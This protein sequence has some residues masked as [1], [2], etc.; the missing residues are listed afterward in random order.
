[1]GMPGVGYNAEAD[2]RSWAAMKEVL[3]EVLK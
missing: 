3:D 1:M 2:R